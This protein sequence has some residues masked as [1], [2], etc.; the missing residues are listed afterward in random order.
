MSD[1]N[2]P[3]HFYADALDKVRAVT[4]KPTGAY[5]A[6]AEMPAAERKLRTAL[7][8]VNHARDLIRDALG[9]N[10]AKA[11]RDAKI[12]Y[13]MASERSSLHELNLSAMQHHPAGIGDVPY[14]RT[15]KW[16]PEWV[17][18]PNCGLHPMNAEAIRDHDERLSGAEDR[19]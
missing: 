6:P 14:E 8:Y 4:G 15:P 9:D 13:D 12:A 7:A 16:S 1:H 10:D 19:L 11:Q 17:K 5:Q 3:D 18:P 2:Y